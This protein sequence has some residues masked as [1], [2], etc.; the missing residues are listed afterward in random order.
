[1]EGSNGNSSTEANR[2]R[3]DNKTAAKATGRKTHSLHNSNDSINSFRNA[4]RTILNV[5]R[6][7]S[8]ALNRCA[9]LRLNVL[10]TMATAIYR[11]RK[12]SI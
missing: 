11:N 1:M 2:G 3:T 10:T 9:K 12:S 8:N 4:T 6:S 7:N 5:R